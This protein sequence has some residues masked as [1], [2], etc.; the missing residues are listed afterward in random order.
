[1][2]SSGR[3]II[4]SNRLP[5]TVG[6]DDGGGLAVTRSVGGL[7]TGLRPMHDARGGIWIGWP[8]D[9]STLTPAERAG[10]DRQLADMSAVPVFLETEESKTFYEDIANG[11]IWPVCHDRLDRLPPRVS[12]WDV[13]ETIN[14]RFADAVAKQWSPGDL[15]WIHDFQLFRAPALVRE[16][17]PDARIGFFLHIP[18][19]NPE[20]F[21]ALPTRSQLVEGIMGADLV[22]FHTRRYHGHFRAALRRLFH[23]EM[24]PDQTVSWRGRKV[25]LG[26]HPMG[27]DARDFAERAS[28][29]EVSAEALALRSDHARLLVGVDRLDYSKGILRRMHA[30]EALLELHPEW[31]ERVRLVQIAVPTRGGVQAYR[32]FRHDLEALVGRINGR[33]GTPTWTPIQYVHRTIADTQLSALYRAADVMLV[34]PL[35]DGMNLVAKEFVA[36]RI[37]EDGVLV[38]SEFAGAADELTDALI[39]NPYDVDGTA[40]TIHRALS[41]DRTE[42]RRR[43]QALRS[44]VMQHDV[45]RWSEGFIDSLAGTP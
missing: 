45:A 44:Q 16:Q 8:G 20:I 36:S 17:I 3:V 15:I 26:V 14:Q 6:R 41:M 27:I 13:Y 22:G 28:N 12:G 10:V 21:F 29:R 42:R 9:L 34:T 30:L 1:V 43:I 7:A 37:D 25:R 38:L 5:I 4:V 32:R 33:F 31:R 11:V 19:P 39:V 18:F 40:H 24:D 35:R 2:S 23:L